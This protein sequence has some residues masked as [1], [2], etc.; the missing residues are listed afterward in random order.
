MLNDTS[1]QIGIFLERERAWRQLM[2][3][4]RQAGMVEIAASVL[5]NIGNVLNSAGVSISSLNE[6]INTSAFVNASKVLGFL[7][8]NATHLQDYLS[9]DARGKLLPEYFIQLLA[10]LELA[11]E[12]LKKESKNIS[13]HFNH[14]N[15]IVNSQSA[16]SGCKSGVIEKIFL[17]DIIDVAL[18]LS[19]HTLASK[20]IRLDKVINSTL[21]VTVDKSRLV[22]IIVNFIQNAK[23]S[24]MCVNDDKLKIISIEVAEN[25]V[26]DCA[27]IIVK[28]NGMG[29]SAENLHK[30]FKF[31]FTTKPKGHGFGL[32]N[33][34]LSAKDLG[35]TI[36]VESEGEGSGATFILR[37]PI[38]ANDKKLDGEI[39]E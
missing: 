12:V 15:E 7:K 5:H 33:S 34:F 1:D 13:T 16:I 36:L 20:N 10:E 11:R 4:Q 24:L 22:Q 3:M 18:Q 6:E 23:D 8:E 39:Y 26:Q 21:F 29:I 38:A 32:Y 31:G 17:P 30:L 37:L 28:D 25:N 14:I 2:E 27:D 19:A 9:Q 35:G